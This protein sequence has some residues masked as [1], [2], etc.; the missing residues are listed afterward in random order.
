[1]YASDRGQKLRPN[2]LKD[3]KLGSP[4]W[5]SGLETGPHRELRVELSRCSGLLRAYSGLLRACSG[6]LRLGTVLHSHSSGLLIH[7]SGCSH[8]CSGL[9]VETEFG[10][11]KFGVRVYW[12]HLLETSFSHPPVE[13]PSF[14]LT[15]IPAFFQVSA[16]NLIS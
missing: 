6:L 8:V 13:L 3:T 9:K 1:M 4:S 11:V 10:E 7:R 15:A 14:P 5:E 2:N 12:H 16:T